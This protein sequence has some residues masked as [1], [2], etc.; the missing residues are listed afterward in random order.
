MDAYVDELHDLVVQHLE[1]A[2]VSEALA[3]MLREEFVGLRREGVRDV[4]GSKLYDIFRYVREGVIKVMVATLAGPSCTLDA[5]ARTTVRDLKIRIATKM[6]VPHWQQRLVHEGRELEDSQ[7]LASR[8]ISPLKP[9]VSV[10]RVQGHQICV[11][12]GEVGNHTGSTSEVLHPAATG[13][14]PL[15]PM[16]TRRLALAAASVDGT[17]YAIGGEDNGECLASVEVLDLVERRWT[18]LPSMSAQRSGFAAATING[19]VYVFGGF[20]GE[21]VL[22]SVEC[23]N[24]SIGVWTSMPPMNSSRTNLGVAVLDN[25]VYAAGGEDGLQYVASVE[26]FDPVVGTWNFVAPMST[27][28]AAFALMALG[29][30]LYA[31]GG[32]DGE[33]NSLDSVEVFNPDTGVW[34][35]APPLTQCRG[36]CVG[37]ALNGQLYVAGG[38]VSSLCPRESSVEIFDPATEAWIPGPSMIVPRS[39]FA[40][41]VL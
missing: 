16:S 23:F 22:S 38:V 3:R 28:R 13:W 17:L 32:D 33:N 29:G 39:V 2:G 7:S 14:F 41:A 21:D 27:C 4:S 5:T 6:S 12:G 9:M 18:P 40:A 35:A 24:P 10:V 30:K 34:A 11:V 15:P 37:V 31:A 25:V 36:E 8:G 26:C 19:L 1:H 20:D